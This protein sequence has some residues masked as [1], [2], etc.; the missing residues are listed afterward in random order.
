MNRYLFEVRF[1]Y[2]GSIGTKYRGFIYV[3]SR[4][5]DVEQ[6]LR[7]RIPTLISIESIAYINEDTLIDTDDWN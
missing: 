7:T 1:S 3:Y 4:F 5:L 2:L 6:T